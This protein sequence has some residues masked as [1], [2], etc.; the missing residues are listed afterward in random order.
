M[1]RSADTRDRRRR[2]APSSALGTPT[3]APSARKYALVT[4]ERARERTLVAFGAQ[5]RVS[6]RNVAAL[7]RCCRR[8]RRRVAWRCARR[9]PSRP[10]SSRR[11]RRAGRC[12]TRT[13]AQRRR[14][15][16]ARSPRTAA[17]GSSE[18]SAAS[19]HASARCESSRPIDSSAAKPSTSRAPIRRSW[20]RLKRRRPDAPAGFVAPPVER[21]ERAP[22]RAR[23]ACSPSRERCRRRAR[24]RTRAGGTARPD[25]RDEPS[26][27]ARALRG[28]R[29][30]AKPARERRA[31][32]VALGQA[33]ELRASRGRDRARPRASPAWPAAAAA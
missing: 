4:A 25:T 28:D 23:R 26:D 9:P 22:H 17:A 7:A 2:R 16:R 30:V 27:A 12:R 1:N 29:R 18:R 33:A 8:S 21:V 24:R 13:T 19:T 11:R 14:A 6:T 15:D 10:R 31:A 32:V 20:R 3:S 5:A